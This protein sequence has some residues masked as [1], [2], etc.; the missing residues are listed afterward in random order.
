MSKV[1]AKKVETKK[2][3]TKS[4]KLEG[5]VKGSHKL[6]GIKYEWEAGEVITCKTKKIFDALK[7]LDS[8]KAK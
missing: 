1:E 5:L 6:Q 2:A 4:Y 7:S 8:L 3:S